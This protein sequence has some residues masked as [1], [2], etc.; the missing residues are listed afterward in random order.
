MKKSI[1]LM[2]ALVGAMAWT[3]CR[4]AEEDVVKAP[5]NLP[6]GSLWLSVEARKSIDTKAL[7]L[8]ENTLNAYWVDG[9]KVAVFLD[10]TYLGDLTAT[11]NTSD[12][13]KATLSGS[14]PSTGVTAGVTLYLLF[15]GR[16]DHAWDY[17]GQVGTAPSASGALATQ[18]DYALAS[19]IVDSVDG[20]SIKTTGSVTFENQQSIYRFSFAE[21]S[22]AL[23]V[24]SFTLSSPNN[25]LV[26]SRSWSGGAWV[27]AYG[28]VAVT[29]SSATTNA[30]YLALRNE[31]SGSDNYSFDIIGNDNA[32]YLAGKEV[33]ATKFANGQFL[34]GLNIAVTKSTLPKNNTSTT[35]VW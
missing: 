5:Q 18:Y 16:T 19:A 20:S 17:S 21:N 3:G 14:L 27:S 28:S 9:E 4:K 15:P 12:R 1:L 26:Q 10:G 35:E 24:K 22:T 2:A 34:S 13:T 33:A 7:E 23:S 30:L 25:K 31:H 11:A 32:L 29:P 6:K 8:D